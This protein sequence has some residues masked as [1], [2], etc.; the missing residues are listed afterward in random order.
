MAGTQISDMTSVAVEDVPTAAQFPFIVETSVGGLSPLAN[1]RASLNSF[2]QEGDNAVARTMPDK[3]RD[4]ISVKDFGAVGDSVTDDTDA[5]NDAIAVASSFGN[6]YISIYIPPGV[7][8]ITGQINIDK[9]KVCLFG[10]GDKSCLYFDPPASGQTMILVQ[11][12]DTSQL[13]NYIQIRDFGVI[14]NPAST[15]KVKTA[16]KMIDASILSMSNVN[17]LDYSWTD[18]TGASKCLHMAGRD[19]HTIRECALIGDMPIYAEPNPNSAQFGF[20]FH[21]F[22]ALYMQVL[23]PDNYAITFAPGVNPSNWVVDQNCGAFTCKGGIYL[24]NTGVTTQT[25]S[26]IRI[27]NFR[28]E[29]GTGAGG[30]TGGWGIYMDFGVP[31]VNNPACGN[32][33][34][35]NSSVND[36][37]TNGYY[38]RNVTSMTVTNINCGFGALD[39]FICEDVNQIELFSLGIG[40]NSAT[41]TFT[42]MEARVLDRPAGAV[43]ADKSIA[44]ALYVLNAAG[45]AAGN[46]SYEDGLRVWGKNATLS[47]G[48]TVVLPALTAGQSMRV[49]VACDGGG[50]DWNLSFTASDLISSAGSATFT[51]DGTGDVSVTSNGSGVSTL[52]NVAL[53][54]SKIFN[55]RTFGS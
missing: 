16:F 3:L 34:L 13:I 27:S 12:A 43:A 8:R 25:P 24:D 9:R 22:S 35:E 54:A 11:N 21:T 32:I 50:A 49:S 1:Y 37:T 14:A 10:A 7:Y 5:F 26:M 29:S 51:D 41:V 52:T 48:G 4:I 36:P 15:A 20:D 23:T 46:L 39:A 53:G 30:A 42:N 38:F 45:T 40:D 17:F 33:I 44:Y 6:A 18:A 47:N 2:L 55:V 28:I 31:G 19:T